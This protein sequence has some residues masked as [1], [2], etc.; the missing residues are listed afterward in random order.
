M[1]KVIVFILLISQVS[2]AGNTVSTVGKTAAGSGRGLG[3][4]I[5]EVSD[6]VWDLSK[7]GTKMPGLALMSGVSFFFPQASI[8]PELV[9]KYRK[10]FKA[11][12]TKR[13]AEMTKYSKAYAVTYGEEEPDDYPCYELEEDRQNKES[14]CFKWCGIS[15]IAAGVGSA[16]TQEW[17]G[18]GGL[19]GLIPGVPAAIQCNKWIKVEH[20]LKECQ[21]NH[22]YEKEQ[23]YTEMEKLHKI[24]VGIN[25]KYKKLKN[26]EKERANERVRQLVKDYAAR[27]ENLKSEKVQE[28][29]RRDKKAIDNE[30]KANLRRIDKEQKDAVNSARG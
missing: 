6:M 8:D 24:I 17:G 1:S 16:T 28:R 12:Y 7:D 19:A 2:Y 5:E 20:E 13:V 25:K 22:I 11:D 10:I 3:R 21:E 26:A 14:A 30:L 4:G 23:A 18:V 15:G 27:G 29:L 9:K